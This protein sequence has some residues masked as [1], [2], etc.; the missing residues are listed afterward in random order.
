MKDNNKDSIHEETLLKESYSGTSK[1][2]IKLGIK[3][4]LENMLEMKPMYLYIYTIIKPQPM[5]NPIIIK[6]IKLLTFVRACVYVYLLA[7]LL[8]SRCPQ[9]LKINI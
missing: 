8:S 3:H 6:L 5:L 1:H 2:Q 4:Q 9:V 7:I